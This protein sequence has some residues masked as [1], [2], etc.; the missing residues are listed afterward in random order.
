MKNNALLFVSILAFFFN[1]CTSI[2]S[3]KS[4]TDLY[5]VTWELEYISGSRIAFEG[6]YP[7]K[8]PQI[9]FNENTKEVLGNSS[10]NGY[11]SKYTLADKSIIFGES[12]PT[13]M[14]YCDG[15]GEQ[16]FLQMIK[17]INNYSIDKDN[18]LNLM[19]GQVPMMRFKKG[20]K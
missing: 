2:K 7:E 5:D 9:V 1:S 3:S 10:C 20:S 13:T 14:M 11:G 15:G 16:V 6:L 17:K 18:K 12:N 4:T 19:I 8:K